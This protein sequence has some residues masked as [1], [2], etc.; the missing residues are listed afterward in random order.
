MKIEIHLD[1][2]ELCNGCMFL[3]DLIED[4]GFYNLSCRLLQR[5]LEKD[6]DKIK[7]VGV[8]RHKICIEKFGE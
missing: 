7:D 6:S 5:S 2:P 1:N 4:D 8:K 3:D